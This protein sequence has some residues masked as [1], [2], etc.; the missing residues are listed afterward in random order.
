[1]QKKLNRNSKKWLR[2]KSLDV[3]VSINRGVRKEEM[4][5]FFKQREPAIFNTNNVATV[6]DV[7]HRTIDEFKGEI[8][9]WSQRGSG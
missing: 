7:F 1:M 5:Y 4:K 2:K 9:A 3:K 8:E 6:S